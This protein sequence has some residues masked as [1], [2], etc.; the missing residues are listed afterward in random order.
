MTQPTATADLAAMTP[1]EIDGQLAELYGRHS[2]LEDRLVSVLGDVHYGIGERP[3]KVVRST[4]RKTWPT[5]DEAAVD[6]ARAK[7][8]AGNMAS[9]DADAL[10]RRLAKFDAVT[11]EL[12]EVRAAMEPLHAEYRNRPWSRFHPVPGG[13]IHSSRS[14]HTLRITTDVRWLPEMSGQDEATAL[15]SL[16][17]AGHILCTVCFPSAPTQYTVKPIATDRCAGGIVPSKEQT[18]IGMRWYGACPTCGGREL[19]NMGGQVRSHK[20]PKSDR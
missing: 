5:T 19:V 11:A 18:R 10:T 8:A 2:A 1:S 4:G 13:H 16:G 14:C 15:N 7:L 12:A 6:A 17:E 3:V 20:T 9:W